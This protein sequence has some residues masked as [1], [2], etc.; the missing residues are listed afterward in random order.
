[1]DSAEAFDLLDWRRRVAELYQRIRAS[2]DPAEAWQAWK[3]DRSRLFSTHPQSPLPVDQRTDHPGLD[4]FS[5]APRYRVLGTIREAEPKHYD[6]QT[7]TDGTYGFTRFAT[8][9]FEIEQEA[10]E[11][12]LYWLDGYGGGLFLPF[13]D[14]TSGNITYGAGRYLLDTV[15]GADLGCDGDKLIIDFNFAYNPSCSYDAKW[16]CPL[17]PPQNKLGLEITAGERLPAREEGAVSGP[18]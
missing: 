9:H 11:L 13:R 6:I 10:L 12:E 3:A 1:M 17:S 8:V 2:P 16:A 7:S 14:A 18:L 5:Y 15:K 4:Y